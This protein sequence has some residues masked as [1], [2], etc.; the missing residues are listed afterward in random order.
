MWL[1]IVCTADN[2]E[3]L[4]GLRYALLSKQN[5]IFKNKTKHGE[6]TKGTQNF[7]D[8]LIVYNDRHFS[9]TERLIRRKRKKP[10]TRYNDFKNII[11]FHKAFFRP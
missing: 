7:I 2:Y 8:Y 10:K 11:R 6:K 4:K 5:V 3:K 1:A 9:E